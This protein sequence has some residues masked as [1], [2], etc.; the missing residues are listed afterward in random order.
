MCGLVRTLASSLEAFRRVVSFVELCHPQAEQRCVFCFALLVASL[1][2]VGTTR[3][4]MLGVGEGR[5][6]PV[7]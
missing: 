7:C 2:S 5:V 3:L 6:G 1:G 4:S